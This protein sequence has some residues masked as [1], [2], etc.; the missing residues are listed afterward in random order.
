MFHSILLQK[1]SKDLVDEVVPPVAYHNSRDSVSR[2]DDGFEQL[3][4]W[5]VIVGRA[6][7]RLNPLGHVIDRNQLAPPQFHHTLGSQCR[8]RP[9]RFSSSLTEGLSLEE[10]VRIM[11]DKREI[12]YRSGSRFL[13]QLDLGLGVLYVELDRAIFDVE[14]IEIESEKGK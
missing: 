6:R 2:K 10:S 4:H 11:T 13:S 5:L 12:P 3:E 8:K 9:T 1:T 7:D 14:G